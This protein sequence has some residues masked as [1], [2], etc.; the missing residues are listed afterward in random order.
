MS[1]AST[2]ISRRTMLRG[3]ASAASALAVG[4][5]AGMAANA[6]R[7]DASEI[8][9]RPT[10]LVATTRKAVNGGRAKP[11]YG[12]ERAPAMSVARLKL[13][14]PDDSRFSLASVG[15]VDWRIA[16][17]EPA[18]QVGDLL[19]QATSGRNVLIYVHGFNQTFEAAALDAARLSDGIKFAGE[20]MVFSWPSRAKLFDYGYDRESAMWS[21]DAFDQ[22]LEGLLASP[23]IGRIN[24]VA[25]SIGT[26]LTM[27]ALRQ[28]YAKHGDAAADRIGAVVFAS[29]DIDV[30]VF[31][32]S[33]ERIGPLAAKITVVAAT[34]DR[35]LAVSRWMNGGTTRVGAAEKAQLEKLGLRV[36]DAS[37]QGWGIINHDLFL[38][39]AGIRQV[40]RDAVGGNAG[41]RAFAPGGIQLGGGLGAPDEAHP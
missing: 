22:V 6:P 3:A 10:L 19:S 34:N 33:V 16:A 15:L 1:F 5:C 36:I 41:L 11:W 17:V 23:T 39:N 38:S 21:R 35:A 8:S 9:A 24:I 29:P 4:G 30:D 37:Q 14:P 26:M 18:Q 20:T 28:L 32:A 2:V 40:I 13:T 7:F 31:A 27:E 25:H 12:P